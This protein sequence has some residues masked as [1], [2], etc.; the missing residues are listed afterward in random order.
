MSRS[1]YL[2]LFLETGHNS[3]VNVMFQLKTD[4]LNASKLI[5]FYISV[6]SRPSLQNTDLKH[7]HFTKNKHKTKKNKWIEQGKS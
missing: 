6:Q 1:N 4:T 5:N 2:Q 3:Y 7:L